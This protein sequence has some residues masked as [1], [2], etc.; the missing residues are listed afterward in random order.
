MLAAAFVSQPSRRSSSTRQ[1]RRP[2]PRISSELCWAMV[3][4]VPIR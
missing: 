3:P 1:A 4:Y 2:P